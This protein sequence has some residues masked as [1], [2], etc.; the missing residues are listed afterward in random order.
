MWK[1]SLKRKV[2]Q[3]YINKYV[4]LMNKNLRNDPLWQGRFVVNQIGSP[5]FFVYPDKSGA[6]YYIT[7]QVLDRETGKTISKTKTSNDWCSW[8]GSDLWWFVNDAI[9]DWRYYNAENDK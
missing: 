5:S 7:L 9:I 1:T 3:R 4:R 2:H 8:N 6:E